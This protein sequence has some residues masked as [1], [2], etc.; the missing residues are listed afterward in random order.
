MGLRTQKPCWDSPE[1]QR[2][3]KLGCTRNSHEKN[4]TAATTTRAS[5]GN[6]I[7]RR[8]DTKTSKQI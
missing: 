3:G 7:T 1:T 6:Y 8:E 4:R 5:K 2:T